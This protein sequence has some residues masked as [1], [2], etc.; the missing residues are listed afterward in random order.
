VIK[1]VD[2]SCSYFKP[3]MPSDADVKVISRSLVDQITVHDRT[4]IAHCGWKFGK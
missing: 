2:N 4:G 3:I 1:T